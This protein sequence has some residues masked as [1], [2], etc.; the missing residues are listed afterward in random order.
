[1]A[2]ASVEVLSAR[3]FSARTFAMAAGAILCLTMTSE[4]LLLIY[5]P[6]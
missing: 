3:M 4:D 5:E 2:A 1:M 6:E